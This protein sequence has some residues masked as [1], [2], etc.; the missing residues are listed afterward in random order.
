MNHPENHSL[1][2]TLLKC[3]I[4]PEFLKVQLLP[5]KEEIIVP[6]NP[7]ATYILFPY[8]TPLRFVEMPEVKDVQL[9]PLYDVM[10]VPD[11]PNPKN[12]FAP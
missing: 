3:S 10:I 7:T 2:Y 6:D 11:A 4:V 8:D 12:L 9:V 1:K 5:S